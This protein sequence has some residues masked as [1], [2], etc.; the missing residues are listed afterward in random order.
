MKGTINDK[1]SSSFVSILFFEV[2]KRVS[3][4]SV[5][6]GSN[7]IIIKTSKLYDPNSSGE[8]SLV[9][10]GTANKDNTCAKNVPV[11]RFNADLL[12]LI[13]VHPLEKSIQN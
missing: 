9:N 10:T 1:T 3:I 2:T 8:Y 4:L 6:I 13:F 7:T 5:E 12:K 11:P